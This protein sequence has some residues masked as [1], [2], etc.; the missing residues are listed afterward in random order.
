M[1]GGLD[2]EGNTEVLEGDGEEMGDGDVQLD[3][4]IDE[5]GS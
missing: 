3:H 5:G 2:A 4:T 1:A